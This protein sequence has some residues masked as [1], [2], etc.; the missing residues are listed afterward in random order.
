MDQAGYN[1][2]QIQTL[3]HQSSNLIRP[4]KVGQY[5]TQGFIGQSEMLLSN[6][7]QKQTLIQ[8]YSSSNIGIAPFSA[9]QI[10]TTPVVSQSITQSQPLLIT[11]S[12][13]IASTQPNNAE[14]HHQERPLQ[15]VT[16][17]DMDS[18]WKTKCM[19][20]EVYLF[21]LQQ[22]NLRLRGNAPQISYVQDDSK[23]N[24]L[25]NTNKELKIQEQGLRQSNKQL[26]DELDQWKL[27]YKQLQESNSKNQGADDEIKLLKKKISSLTD[28]LKSSQEQNQFKDQEIRKLKLLMNDKDNEL[29]SLDQRIREL[30]L[31]LESFSQSE[32]Q[33]ISLQGEVELW[34]K[35]FKQQNEINSDISEKL[36]MAETQLEALKKSKVTVTKESEIK[37]TGPSGTGVTTQF[38]TSTI[39]GAT[40]GP[41]GYSTYGSNNSGRN[42]VVRNSGYNER[43]Q[44]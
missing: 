21:D 33:I 29:E 17:D 18:R 36:T 32:Q 30:E 43:K 24:E 20:L 38:E 26:Q 35:K 28:D 9:R 16:L 41:G 6:P 31:Q 8:Q 27:R 34:K 23:I 1:H 11:P 3:L 2:S 15:V 4:P 44:L 10:A 39:K 12:V 19:Q 5:N 13:R 22:E 37:R 25:I 7:Q 42:S 40:I 14:V